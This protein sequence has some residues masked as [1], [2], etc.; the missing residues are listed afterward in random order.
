V[1]RVI[2]KV[3]KILEKEEY[4]E[5]VVSFDVGSWNGLYGECSS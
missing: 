4:Y 3:V 5:E 2:E 1:G